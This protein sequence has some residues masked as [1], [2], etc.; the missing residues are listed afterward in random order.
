MSTGKSIYIASAADGILVSCQWQQRE[1]G[2]QNMQRRV[3]RGVRGW[4]RV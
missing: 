2:C 3:G 1:R 4:G